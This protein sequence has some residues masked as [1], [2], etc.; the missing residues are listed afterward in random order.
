VVPTHG[1]KGAL[2][3]RISRRMEIAPKKREAPCLKCLSA[4]L[5]IRCFQRF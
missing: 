2:E 3:N 5:K 1:A 4:G